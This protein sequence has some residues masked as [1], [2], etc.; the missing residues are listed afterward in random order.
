MRFSKIGQDMNILHSVAYYNLSWSDRMKK[1]NKCGIEYS[2]NTKFCSECGGQV[3]AVPKVHTYKLHCKSCN[4][5]MTIED[6]SPILTCPF[7]GSKELISESDT[8][9]VERI[10]QKVHRDIEMGKQQLERERMQHDFQVTEEQKKANDIRKFRK[11]FMG[12]MLIIVAVISVLFCAVSFND[13]RILSGI[14]AIVIGVLCVASYLMGIRVIKEKFNGMRIVTAIL[15][16]VLIIP[17]FYLYNGAKTSY[18]EKPKDF[19]WTILEMHEYIPEPSSTYGVIGLDYV[20][21]L[22]VDIYN[23]SYAEYKEYRNECIDLGYVKDTSGGGDIYSAYNDE[24]F[25]LSLF[26]YEDEEK[27]GIILSAP[28]EE[29]KTLNT[30]ESTSANVVETNVATEKPTEKTAEAPTQP[31]TQA[32]KAP[33][34]KYEKAFIRDM[35]DYDLYFMF[36]VDKK[37]VIYFGTHDTYIQEGIYSGDF[38]TGIDIN[39]INDGWHETF[40]CETGSGKATLID[41]NGFDW[42]YKICDVEDAQEILDSIK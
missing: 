18:K 39:W 5:T 8:V 9:T 13:N 22:S 38:S 10:K 30:E 11:S 42:E 40:T 23:I 28:E 24:G 20:D 1:C 15:A 17:Y 37:E 4:G 12:I 25:S 19:E 27:L 26:Y 2:D 33:T 32:T 29:T 34:S 35:R 21:Y 6:D 3:V 14:V 16:F 36:D 31:P 7:C 41:G